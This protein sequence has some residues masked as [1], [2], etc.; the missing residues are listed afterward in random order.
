MTILN[1]WSDGADKLARQ[2][3]FLK[4]LNGFQMFGVNV[5]CSVYRMALGMTSKKARYK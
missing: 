4:Q 2:A 3:V 1:H 5:S